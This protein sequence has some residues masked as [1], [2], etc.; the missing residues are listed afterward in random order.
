MTTPNADEPFGSGNS[1]LQLGPPPGMDGGTHFGV[2]A[3][4]NVVAT[5]A[6][7]GYWPSFPETRNVTFDAANFVPTIVSRSSVGDP[8]GGPESSAPKE[9]TVT[10]AA[11]V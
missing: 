8:G 4:V 3:K 5:W 7:V 9:W 6:G 10:P 2:G 1:A 11:G